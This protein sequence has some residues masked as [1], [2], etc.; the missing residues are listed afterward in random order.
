MPTS[1]LCT[2][3]GCSRRLLARGMCSTH[4]MRVRRTGS[5]DHI[6]RTYAEMLWQ[7]FQRVESG[8]WEWVGYVERDG[9]GRY[10]VDGVPRPAHRLLYE[11]LVGPV[12]A[13]LHLDHLCRNRRCVNP[14]HLEPVTPQENTRRGMRATATHCQRGHAF[15]EA[16]TLWYRGTR[17]CRQCR[18]ERTQKLNARRREA[19]RARVS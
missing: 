10:K 18:D 19:R 12:P 2:I 14:M 6:P 13:E 3:D 5:L 1:S 11:M 9:Y 8:C 16:N 17:S 7:R 15:D 4:Y